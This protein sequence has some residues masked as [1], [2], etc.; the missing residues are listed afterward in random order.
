[1]KRISLLVLSLCATAW[2]SGCCCCGYYS[3]YS[4]CTDDVCVQSEH[5]HHGRHRHR[6]RDKGERCEIGDGDC[7][8]NC[9]DPCCDGSVGSGPAIPTAPMTYNGGSAMLNGAPA[10]GGC[11]TC[12]TAQAFGGTVQ[13]YGA[14][15][16]DPGSGWTIQSMTSTPVGN[17]PVM[18]PPS[19][20]TPGTPI[21]PAPAR[22]QGW[23]PTINPSST[24]SQGTV[25]PPVS[26]NR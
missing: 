8:G 7:C 13:N 4:D 15:P 16:F 22:T 18:A 9:C 23:A 14:M 17:E 6:R 2:A 1:M 21:T 10:T 20:S 12:G 11:A 25:P 24:P 3:R 26:Y 19:S 5:R